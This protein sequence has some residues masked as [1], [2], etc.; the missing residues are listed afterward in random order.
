MNAAHPTVSVRYHGDGATVRFTPWRGAAKPAPRRKADPLAE[1]L[2]IVEGAAE[3]CHLAGRE[4][5]ALALLKIVDGL[6]HVMEDGRY[7]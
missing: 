5:R 7:V 3:E 6:R 4:T 2:R 1:A